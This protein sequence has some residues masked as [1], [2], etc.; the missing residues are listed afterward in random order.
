M[1]LLRDLSMN[2]PDELEE[3]LK[4][5]A[6][7]MPPDPEPWL[8]EYRFHYDDTGYIH[9]VTMLEHPKDTQYVVGT[10]HEY[11]HQSE[12]KVVDNKLKLI[13][14]PSGFRVK[15]KSSLS[16]YPVVRNHAGILLENETHND[17]EYYDNN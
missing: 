11:D 12:Y 1:R 4:E 8:L 10:K 3:F 5:V 2:Q 6:K 13:D 15:L 14:K 9:M 16:G 7:L 17:V